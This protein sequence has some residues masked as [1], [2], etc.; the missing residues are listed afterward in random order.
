MVI[1]ID[2]ISTLGLW[3]RAMTYDPGRCRRALPLP[4]A[5]FHILLALSAGDCHGYG[6][7][8]DVEARTSGALRLSPGT[9]YR[10]IQR[11]LDDGLIEEP[12]KPSG[13]KDRPA[14]ALLPHHSIRHGRRPGRSCAGSPNWF[15]W[16]RASCGWRRSRD[17]PVLPRPA[18]PLSSVVPDG[19]RR[20]D[21][22]GVR[23]SV[24][25]CHS[26][27]QGRVAAAHHRRRGCERARRALGNPDPGPALHRSFGQP[28]ARLCHHRNPRHG[29]WRWRQHRRVLGRR[30]RAAPPVAVR[31]SRHFG[32]AL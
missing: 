2:N 17:D 3:W 20:R 5:A 6:I 4:P 13:P 14:A 26:T 22:G 32:S 28:R 24:R 8:Q 9:L 18:P 1:S 21:D 7:I 19:V 30:F 29:T 31:R 12:R 10:T 25:R 27:G 16:P 23:T 11:L 15:G